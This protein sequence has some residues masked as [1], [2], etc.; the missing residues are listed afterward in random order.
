MDNNIFAIYDEKQREKLKAEA[1]QRSEWGMIQR[2]RL[3]DLI[4]KTG[5]IIN[6]C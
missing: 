2:K 1:A 3:V 4:E 6:K 5:E